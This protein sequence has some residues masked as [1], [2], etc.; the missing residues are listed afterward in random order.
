MEDD[1]LICVWT[2]SS[3]LNGI[4]LTLTPVTKGLSHVAEPAKKQNCKA[5]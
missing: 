2:S 3:C 5:G 1:N 4:Y